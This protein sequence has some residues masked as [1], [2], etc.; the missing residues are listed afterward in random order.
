MREIIEDV[1]EKLMEYDF[2]KASAISAYLM[3]LGLFMGAIF[4]AYGASFRASTFF[5][6]MIPLS[7]IIYILIKIKKWG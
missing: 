7:I 1:C 2:Y 5:N 3:S 4:N 6:A